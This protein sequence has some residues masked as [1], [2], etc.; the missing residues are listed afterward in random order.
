[1]RLVDTGTRREGCVLEVVDGLGRAVPVTGVRS[2][3]FRPDGAVLAT[4]DAA[5]RVA[6]WDAETG[7]RSSEAAYL[8]QVADVAF[9]PDGATVAVLRRDGAVQLRDAVSRRTWASVSDPA[10]EV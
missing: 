7:W 8:D 6:L 10:G 9:L 1:M 2:V 3:R 5:G 4:V